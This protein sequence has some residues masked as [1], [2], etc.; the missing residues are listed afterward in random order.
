MDISI[1]CGS[2]QKSSASVRLKYLNKTLN[3]ESDGTG[4]IDAVFKAI[5][6][7][8]TT[9][10][11]LVVY[12]VNG[13]TKGPDAQAE[14]SVRLEEAGISVLGMGSDIDT[15]VASGKAYINGLNKLIKKKN[16]PKDSKKILNSSNS[17]I[18]KHVI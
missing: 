8:I 9:K 17:T 10:A 4:P 18:D 13:I 14:V 11:P 6:N 16:K 2:S 1:K 3:G 7:L 5:K 15:I 12:Q